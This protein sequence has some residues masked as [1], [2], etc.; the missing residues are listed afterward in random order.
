MARPTPTL[1]LTNVQPSDAVDYRVVVADHSGS[2]NSGTA[3]LYVLPP[4]QL[5]ISR[6]GP[7]LVTLS[8][9]GSMALLLSRS[10]DCPVWVLVGGTS[11]A[12]VSLVSSNAFQPGISGD[13]FFFRLVA[14][15]SRAELYADFENN[16]DITRDVSVDPATRLRASD[17]CVADYFLFAPVVRAQD[18]AG[19]VL[20]ANPYAQE[21]ASTGIELDP[22]DCVVAAELAWLSYI[23]YRTYGP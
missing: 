3:H 10:L 19:P 1:R 21:A 5:L 17:A 6:P 22:S 4:E 15:H 9:Q 13:Q 2:T 8:W 16:L 20:T 14:L 23:S 7:G 12:T 11:P 18:Y